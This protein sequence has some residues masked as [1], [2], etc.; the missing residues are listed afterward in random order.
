MKHIK[1]VFNRC[2]TL[3][4]PL[5]PDVRGA[6]AGAVGLMAETWKVVKQNVTI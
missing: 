2:V 6:G 5:P 3:L 1:C 4:S